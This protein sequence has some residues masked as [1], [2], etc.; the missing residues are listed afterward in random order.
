MSQFAIIACLGSLVSLLSLISARNFLYNIFTKPIMGFGPT[1]TLCARSLVVGGMLLNLAVWWTASGQTVMIVYYT[2]AYGLNYGG[3]LYARLFPSGHVA[4]MIGLSKQLRHEA[5][6]KEM[7][8]IAERQV[9][10]GI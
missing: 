10:W 8:S 1:F 3:R 5:A 6:V 4:Q 2:L 9:D 7:H